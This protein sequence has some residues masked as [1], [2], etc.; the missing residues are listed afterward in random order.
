MTL[1][2]AYM[3][4]LADVAMSLLGILSEQIGCVAKFYTDVLLISLHS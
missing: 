4:S 1:N 3:M 2:S